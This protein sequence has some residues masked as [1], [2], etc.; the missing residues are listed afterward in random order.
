[1]AAFK[2]AASVV[3]YAPFIGEL[4]PAAARA[5]TRCRLRR[6]GSQAPREFGW[7]AGGKAR[8][9]GI[10]WIRIARPQLHDSRSRVGLSLHPTWLLETRA[11]ERCGYAPGCAP[12]S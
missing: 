6:S 11:S 1:M 12:A 4:A 10:G 3:M 5:P 9:G 8:Q 7:E 2:P